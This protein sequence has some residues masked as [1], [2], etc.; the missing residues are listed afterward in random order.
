MN[1]DKSILPSALDPL[2]IP[3]ALFDVPTMVSIS[4]KNKIH[5]AAD[6]ARENVL[7]ITASASPTYDDAY[8]SAGERARKATPTDPAAARTNVVLAQ[9]GGPCSS[10]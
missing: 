10:I 3:L 9:P 4:S 2:S 6:R 1:I 7:L 8:T 5:G